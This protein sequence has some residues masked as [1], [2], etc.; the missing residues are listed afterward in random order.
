MILYSVYNLPILL[1][2]ETLKHARPSVR[3]RGGCGVVGRS[4]TFAYW[5]KRNGVFRQYAKVG[6]RPTRGG[7][8]GGYRSIKKWPVRNWLIRFNGVGRPRIINITWIGNPQKFV[9]RS[10]FRMNYS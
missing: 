7:G 3:K 4:P 2:V 1:F 6:L 10:S 5:R 9:S 8:G